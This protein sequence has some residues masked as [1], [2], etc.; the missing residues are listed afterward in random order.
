MDHADDERL[1]ATLDE[2]ALALARDLQPSIIPPDAVRQTLLA[3]T[4]ADSFRD[5]LADEGTWVAHPVPGVRVKLLSRDAAR[6]YVVYLAEASPRTEFPSHD[7]SGPEEC[8]V[9]QGEVTINGRTLHAGDFHHAPARTTHSP[10]FTETGCV[11]LLV[12]DA[13]DYIG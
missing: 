12:A 10:L 13:R 5:V 6:G 9:L 8:F 1:A 2:F 11:V 7:H 4:T 3:Q